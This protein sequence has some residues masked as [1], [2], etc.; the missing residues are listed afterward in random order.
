MKGTEI[1]SINDE[2]NC[3]GNHRYYTE[4]AYSYKLKGIDFY[5]Q[6]MKFYQKAINV[7]KSQAPSSEW[8]RIIKFNHQNME[9]MKQELNK[10]RIN[11]DNSCHHIDE[12]VKHNHNDCKI[13]INERNPATAVT[14]SKLSKMEKR[15]QASYLDSFNLKQCQSLPLAEQES[16]LYKIVENCDTSRDIVDLNE[17]GI[18]MIGDG[19]DLAQFPGKTKLIYTP[20]SRISLFRQTE[21][22]LVSKGYDN[23]QLNKL[24]MEMYYKY[25]KANASKCGSFAHFIQTYYDQD[26]FCHGI[27]ILG[28]CSQGN[29]CIFDHSL[30]CLNQLIGP[31][32]INLGNAKQYV[33]FIKYFFYLYSNIT[34]DKIQSMYNYN[35]L[36]SALYSHF[37]NAILVTSSEKQRFDIVDVFFDKAFEYY[38]T[39]VRRIVVHAKVA[40]ELLDNWDKAN[41]FYNKAL[42]VRRSKKPYVAFSYALALQERGMLNRACEMFE[43]AIQ[44][45]GDSSNYCLK[46]GLLLM[47]MPNGKK[48]TLYPKALKYLNQA[49]KIETSSRRFKCKM[50]IVD[51]AKECIRQ[52]ES[53]MNSTNGTNNMNKANDFGINIPVND[54][55]A[56]DKFW[57]DLAW[58]EPWKSKY[59]NL[60]V[61]HKRNNIQYCI[62]NDRNEI[63]LFLM[64]DIK[65]N[66]IHCKYY[67][68]QFREGIGSV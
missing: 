44:S 4:L 57:N 45:K 51:Q 68:K 41:Y 60:I 33:H 18:K 56:F 28:Y 66:M 29:T 32:D 64:N 43:H 22:E 8:K 13:N 62:E 48:L 50:H 52:I 46:Y 37:G 26:L 35:S 9:E 6:S 36:L 11:F 59:Y 19:A 55:G 17:R 27:A 25:Y 61:K 21:Q 15:T 14:T 49:V 67:L 31:F 1:R 53:S 12:D 38:G 24:K 39:S 3:I 20:Q 63:K 47:N 23:Q 40:D 16:Y 30:L 10:K 65:M 42:E 7:L 5:P 54:C 34:S 2:H 58:I